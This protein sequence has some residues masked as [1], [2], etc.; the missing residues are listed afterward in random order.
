MPFRVLATLFWWLLGISDLTRVG[1]GFLIPFVFALT[2]G[3]FFWA[4]L[5][6]RLGLKAFVPFWPL[7]HPKFSL[8]LLF[9]KPGRPAEWFLF[10]ASVSGLFF[11]LFGSS[12][13]S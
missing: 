2:A 12:I 5:L 8:W 4:M 3:L 10:I 11:A 6:F 7:F 13:F 9:G 1:W